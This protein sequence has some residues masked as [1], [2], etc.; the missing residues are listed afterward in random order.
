MVEP[1]GSFAKIVH[2]A[3]QSAERFHPFGVHVLLNRWIQNPTP[4]VE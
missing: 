4:R 2:I 1:T 3:A